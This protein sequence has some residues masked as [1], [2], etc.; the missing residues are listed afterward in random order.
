MGQVMQSPDS[1]QKS[2]F[3][4]GVSWI[5]RIPYILYSLEVGGILLVLPWLPIWDNNYLLYLYPH[6]RSIVANPFLKGAV[7]GLGILNILI[8]IQEIVEFRKVLK[9]QVPR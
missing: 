3:R 5:W 7:L 1:A 6:V 2:P 8:G 9:G 4:S